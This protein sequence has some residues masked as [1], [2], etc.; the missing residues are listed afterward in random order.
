MDLSCGRAAGTS[1]QA[2]RLF[3]SEISLKTEFKV[4]IEVVRVTEK[5]LAAKA[6]HLL[7]LPTMRALTFRFSPH[8][9]TRYHFSHLPLPLIKSEI[10]ATRPLPIRIRIRTSCRFFTGL[11]RALMDRLWRLLSSSNLSLPKPSTG[12]RNKSRADLSAMALGDCIVLLT[13]TED[14]TSS[15]SFCWSQTA[16]LVQSVKVEAIK[17]T[18]S[19]D[20]IISGGIEVVMWKRKEKS[21]EIAWSF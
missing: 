19:G 16:I 4:E 1:S 17:W 15:S 12:G 5:N 14:D 8:T 2:R 10:I 9:P 13:Y 21:W 3:K 6:N 11:R 20:G 18:G 7:L